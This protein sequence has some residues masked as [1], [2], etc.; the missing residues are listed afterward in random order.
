MIVNFCSTVEN[1]KKFFPVY[2][3][4]PVEGRKFSLQFSRVA[5]EAMSGWG[6][7]ILCLDELSTEQWS[8]SVLF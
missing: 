5:D 4:L 8:I 3:V 7:R 1:E 6:E 2:L